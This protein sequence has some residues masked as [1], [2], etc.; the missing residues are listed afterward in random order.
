MITVKR[1]ARGAVYRVELGTA[2][3]LVLE[4]GRDAG[5]V[6]QGTFSF[7]SKV[8]CIKQHKQ[9]NDSDRRPARLPSRGT[10]KFKPAEHIEH[11]RE[12]RGANESVEWTRV[13]RE[14]ESSKNGH[15]VVLLQRLSSLSSKRSRDLHAKRARRRRRARQE[16]TSCNGLDLAGNIRAAVRRWKGD[17][18]SGPAAGA[19]A[20][21]SKV[22]PRAEGGRGGRGRSRRRRGSRGPAGDD[23]SRRHRRRRATIEAPLRQAQGFSYSRGRLET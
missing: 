13:R 3:S 1:E 2:V 21:C 20:S 12:D 6:A 16:P 18:G 22:G 7:I 4:R 23:P 19:D 11:Y 5:L 8:V 10:N 15:G 17:D 9:T 14:H